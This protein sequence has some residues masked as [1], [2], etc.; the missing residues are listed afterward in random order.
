[1]FQQEIFFRE[2]GKFSRAAV[3]VRNLKD[4]KSKVN[5]RKHTHS[6]SRAAPLTTKGQPGFPAPPQGADDRNAHWMTKELILFA[7]SPKMP[8][9]QPSPGPKPIMLFSFDSNPPPRQ[10]R[11][12]G[13]KPFAKSPGHRTSQPLPGPS[14]PRAFMLMFG[15][16]WVSL[17]WMYWT[18]VRPVKIGRHHERQA[19]RQ[20]NSN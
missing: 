17:I 14:R 4:F 11:G 6:C 13:T 15:I 10:R 12:H 3:W 2:N 19:A 7:M 5:D 9:R 20:A 1:M 16:V 18:E 8:P